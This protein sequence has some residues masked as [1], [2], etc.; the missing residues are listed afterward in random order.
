MDQ[1]LCG[2][3]L[4]GFAQKV[5]CEPPLA[6][7]GGSPPHEGENTLA[8]FADVIVPLVRGTAAEGGRGGSHRT[9]CAKPSRAHCRGSEKLRAE[10][11]C[12][13]I[14]PGVNTSQA[15]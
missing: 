13:K 4:T 5:R 2:P 15:H 14:H 3:A 9:F 10:A 8:D 6:A 1:I 11:V 12:F 7:F